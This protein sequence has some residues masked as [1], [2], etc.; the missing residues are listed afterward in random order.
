VKLF[1]NFQLAISLIFVEFSKAPFFLK[2][3]K[4]LNFVNNTMPMFFAPF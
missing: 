3:G 2:F 4:K 1:S